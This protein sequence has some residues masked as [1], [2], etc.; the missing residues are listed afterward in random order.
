MT[1]KLSVLGLRMGDSARKSFVVRYGEHLAKTSQYI[2]MTEFIIARLSAEVGFPPAT[3]KRSKSKHKLAQFQVKMP[4][5]LHEK[6]TQVAESRDV[7]CN[8]LVV[9]II[10][11]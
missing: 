9:G 4:L 6:V 5:I 7:S 8:K 2:S 1:E 11:R 10:T 3:L